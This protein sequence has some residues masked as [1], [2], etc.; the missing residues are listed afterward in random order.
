MH[1]KEP[2]RWINPCGV[3]LTGDADRTPGNSITDAEMLENIVTQAEIACSKAEDVKNEFAPIFFKMDAGEVHELLKNQHY[4]DWLPNW[5]KQYG[6]QVPEEHLNSLELN[7]SLL[8]AYHNLQRI[9]VGIETIVADLQYNQ[10][11]MVKQFKDTEDNLRNVLCEIQMT[12]MQRNILSQMHPDVQR[13][14]MPEKY[15]DMGSGTDR[16][17]RNWIFLR[18][19]INGLQYIIQSLGFIKNKL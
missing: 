8:D 16:K 2:P 10:E 17:A 9:A 12:I 7:K 6:E 14:D 13:E 5:H 15:R 11:P 4:S 19:Y 1:S 18:E 3:Q